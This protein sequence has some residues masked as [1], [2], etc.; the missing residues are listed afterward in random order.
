MYSIEAAAATTVWATTGSSESR[1]T[2]F[3]PL[4][5]FVVPKEFVP[6]ARNMSMRFALNAETLQEGN[7]SQ[8]IHDACSNSPRTAATS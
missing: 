2:P 7:T 3:A 6:N 5:P 8:M 1:V 4:G